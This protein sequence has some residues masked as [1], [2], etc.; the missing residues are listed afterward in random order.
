MQIAGDDYVPLKAFFA[1][2]VERLMALPHL[3]AEDHP[4]AALERMEAR[5][6]AAARKGLA[7]AIGDIVELTEGL[8]A[9]EL[10]DLEAGLAQAGLLSLRRVKARFGRAVEGILRRDNIRNEPEY[11][12][13]RN[14][15]DY[16]GE[17]R[18][19]QAWGLLAAYEA[20]VTSKEPSNDS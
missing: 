16:L 9:L 11:H 1:W 10:D 14:A 18:Q 8:P 15:A 4:V 12:I 3:P 6:N 19:G 7:M 13:L 17:E 5:S 2:M 20:H